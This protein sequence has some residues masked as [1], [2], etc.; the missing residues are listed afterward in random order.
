MI[1]RDTG[2][3]ELSPRRNTPAMATV[4]GGDE[5]RAS[6]P[7]VRVIFT[8]SLLLVSMAAAAGDPAE[9][10]AAVLAPLNQGPASLSPDGRHLACVMGDGDQ[11]VLALVTVDGL[12][13]EFTLSLGKAAIRST[14][15]ADRRQPVRVGLLRWIDNNRVITSTSLNDIIVVH[16]AEKKVRHLVDFNDEKGILEPGYGLRVTGTMNSGKVMGAIVALPVEEPDVAYVSARYYGYNALSES[17]AS[18]SW[19]RLYKINLTTGAGEIVF[20]DTELRR[21]VFDSRGQVRGWLDESAG[22][23]SLRYRQGDLKPAKWPAFDSLYPEASAVPA[24]KPAEAYFGP[25]AFPLAFDLDPNVVYFSSSVGRNTLGVYSLDLRTGQRGSVAFESG[26]ED[27]GNVVAG[28]M[29]SNLAIDRATRRTVGIRL[30]GVRPKTLWLDPELKAMQEKIETLAP[31]HVV[32]ILEWSDT[33]DTVLA[34]L[35]SRSHRGTYYLY[36]PATGKLTPVMALAS[37][38]PAV[39]RA[40]TRPWALKRPDGTVLSGLLTLPEK[41]AV[42]PAPVIVFLQKEH[43]RPLAHY[44][45]GEVMALAQ[46]GFA[47]IEVGHRGTSGMGNANWLAGRGRS[48]EVAAEDVLAALE[49]LPK[50]SIIDTGKIAIM[51]EGFGGYLAL[52]LLQLQPERFTC[53]VALEPITN[54]NQWLNEAESQ[55]RYGQFA[56]QTRKWYFGTDRARLAAQ[57]PDTRPETLVKPLFLAA[58]D[59]SNRRSSSNVPQLRRQLTKAG[60]PPTYAESASAEFT[61]GRENAPLFVQIEAFLRQHL[62]EQA[63]QPAAA[64]P[65]ASR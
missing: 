45:Q 23:P 56:F 3:Q 14:D 43:W 63:G 5:N 7:A 35:F 22:N 33:R 21:F 12:K 31:A 29:P 54:L 19:F 13:T 4:D 53:G 8:L 1:F 6:S 10:F 48:D 58:L 52:R 42:T 34:L 47:V 30:A 44:F 55:T 32:G 39:M 2:L 26:T 9:K 59:Y 57:S 61:L 40:T 41:P 15:K 37:D 65:E 17:F 64:H 60:R 36:R 51:G 11:T 46:M 28:P 16:C 18:D 20:E 25:R 49:A 38:S 50:N 24:S 27:L 62:V